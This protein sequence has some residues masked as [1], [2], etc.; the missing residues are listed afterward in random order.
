[1]QYQEETMQ[2]TSTLHARVGMLG[3]LVTCVTV[4]ACA[5]RVTG[6]EPA[7]TA[8]DV[9]L[10]REGTRVKCDPDNGGITLP[11]GFC[12]VVVADQ[13]GRARHLDLTR[14]GDAY[15]A[16]DDAT[17][18]GGVLA[19]RDRNGD[20]RA[21]EQVYFGDPRA[22]GIVVTD[23]FLYVGYRDRI[24]RW[25]LHSRDLVPSGAPE[26]VVSGLP[27]TG[28]HARK[29]IQID[30]NG[31][32]YVNIGSASN[33][34]QV[35]NRVAQSPGVDP[36]PEL[37]IRAGVWRFRA[38]Q[39]GQTQASGIRFATGLRNMEAL[40]WD[41]TRKALFGVQHGRDH[42]NDH[43]PQFF[44]P[45]DGA[46]LPSEEFIRID[47]GDDNGWP[48]C[49]HD[50]KKNLK[51]LAPEYGGNGNIVGSR[52]ATKERPLLAFPGHWA[53]ND[54]LFYT[55][56]Q[57]PSRFTEGAFVAFHGGFDRS[58]LPNEG[59][60]VVFAPFGRR[61]PEGG[62]EVF[63]D[64]FI[65]NSQNPPADAEHRPMGLA[66]G[67]DGSLYITDDDGGRIWRVV[68]RGEDR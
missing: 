10:R 17:H 13:V 39:V 3:A 47:L 57:F 61:G 20:G 37:P 22:N 1:M 33:S 31:N 48:Y 46:D 15:V 60:N 45:Q 32:M 38:D 58:P 66:E 67:P 40:R 34:C 50:W 35:A 27:A 51:L 30:D 6:P 8:T 25:R 29:N 18:P 65:G 54:L 64:N 9:A 23:E 26:I 24:V 43:F 49:Y 63:A 14:D 41:E 56:S 59:F 42:L 36:C 52:C 2:K 5:D 16:I 12:A 62:W 53:P 4:A 55:G 21:D 28:D 7:Q 44:T 11:S 68:F 19:L